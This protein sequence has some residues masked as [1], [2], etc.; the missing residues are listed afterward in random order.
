MTTVDA[1]PADASSSIPSAPTQ[2][3][4]ADPQLQPTEAPDLLGYL[5]TIHDPRSPRRRR[6]PLVAILAMTAAAVLTGALAGR[7]RRVG[8]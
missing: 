4:H 5:A 1:P 6:H 8:R 2:L 7:D 3:T